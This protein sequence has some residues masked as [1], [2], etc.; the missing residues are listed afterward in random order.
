MCSLCDDDAPKVAEYTY[1]YLF[2]NG[3]KA[4]DLSEVATALYLV[5]LHLQEDQCHNRSVAPFIHFGI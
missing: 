5:K 3:L 4:L 1:K 2:C